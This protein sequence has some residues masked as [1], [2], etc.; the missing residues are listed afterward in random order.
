MKTLEIGSWRNGEF[1]KTAFYKNGKI[2][3]QSYGP[4]TDRTNKNSYSYR[5]EN[6]TYSINTLMQELHSMFIDFS[7]FNFS[8]FGDKLEYS[9]SHGY[10]YDNMTEIVEKRELILK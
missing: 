10:N 4:H 3:V 2:L 6:C 1:E 5:T 8:M 9:I 7:G